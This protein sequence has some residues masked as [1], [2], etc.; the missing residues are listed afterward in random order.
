MN[1]KKLLTLVLVL[2]LAAASLV[3]G[4]LAYF[5]DDASATNTFTMGNVEIEVIED[6]DQGSNLMPGVDINKDVWVQN[7][8]T[9][10][11][12]VRVHIAFPAKMDDGN[13]EFAAVNNFLHWNFTKESIADGQ[14][15]WLPEYSEGV[16]YKGNGVGNWN[17][18]ETTIHGEAY[19]VYV[20]TYRSEVAAGALTGT[21]ALDKV[22]LD[23]SVDVDTNRNDEG[24]V[25]SYT[26][27]DNKGNTFT[28]TPAEASNIKIY[29]VA[30][31]TQ[32]DTFDNAYDALNTAF[33]NPVGP[34][35][36]AGYEVEWPELPQE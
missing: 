31:A 15:S 9:N 4:T 12:Y 18:Y 25:V 2:A 21:Q 5:T 23:T 10:P 1:K 14:W 17:Y 6:Y 22:Y 24:E 20:A 35:Y 33:G 27:F 13:P 3:G 19:N 11:A 28:L 30:E 29:V 32:V 26:Y 36:T 34:N 16:G 7:I 8:G